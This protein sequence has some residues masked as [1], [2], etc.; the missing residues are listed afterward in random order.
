VRKHFQVKASINDLWR[1]GRAKSNNKCSMISMMKHFYFLKPPRVSRGMFFRDEN[2][3][4]WFVII[5][6]VIFVES[7]DKSVPISCLPKINEIFHSP[8]IS[9]PM[10]RRVF[11]I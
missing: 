9:K 8:R 2:F 4:L 11:T 1:G 5:F 7:H 3:Q 10:R 6:R